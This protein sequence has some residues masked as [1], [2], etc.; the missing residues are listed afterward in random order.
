MSEKQIIEISWRGPF[1]L[2]EVNASEYQNGL[3]FFVGK[4]PYERVSTIQYI[5]ITE[6]LFKNRFKKHHKLT[7][8]T[9]EL[10]IWLG[11]VDFPSTFTRNQF[12]VA[13]KI[14]LYFWQ[15]ELNE[16]LR[17]SIPKPTAV[18]STWHKQNGDVRIN[19]RKE[20]A[21]L[22]DVISWN[23]EHWRLGNLKMFE[24]G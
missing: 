1:T 19:K 13:E 3:Y 8:V 9:R 11:H 20:L 22:Y 24:D 18:I 21:P 23:G 7:Q 2:A 4:R 16:K 15:P 14:L 5:G 12:D 10:S 6:G 17:V